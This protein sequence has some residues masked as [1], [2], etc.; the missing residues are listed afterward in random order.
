MKK[1]FLI[2][3]MCCIHITKIV[4]Q[5]LPAIK[6][7][8]WGMKYENVVK[9]LQLK[10]I[11]YT[12]CSE[13]ETS[14]V[15]SDYHLLMSQIGVSEGYNTVFRFNENNE[16]FCILIIMRKDKFDTLQKDNIIKNV[17]DFVTMTNVEWLFLRKKYGEETF[18]NLPDTSK[19][20]FEQKIFWSFDDGAIE[21]RRAWYGTYR[22]CKDYAFYV[23]IQCE[24]YVD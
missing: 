21:L 5:D 23:A 8:I 4:A 15:C 3:I 20:N 12:E 9:K 14:I 13:K 22:K 7:Y 11:D 1:Y 18:K 2:C 24:T 19:D 16:L 17:T 6:G 10:K